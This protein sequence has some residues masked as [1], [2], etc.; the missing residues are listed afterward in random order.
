MFNNFFNEKQFFKKYF[1][2]LFHLLLEAI[3][4]NDYTNIIK[5]Y[6]VKMDEITPKIGNLTISMI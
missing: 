2:K 5:K 3:L 1:L 4:K 6:L